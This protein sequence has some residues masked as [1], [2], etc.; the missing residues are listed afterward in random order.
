MTRLREIGAANAS[1]VVPLPVDALGVDALYAARSGWRAGFTR[2]VTSA[3]LR[4]SVADRRHRRSTGWDGSTP[5]DEDDHAGRPA[6]QLMSYS[7]RR[8]RG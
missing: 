8:L 2:L 7:S 1:P 3:A 5:A 4:W 6:T